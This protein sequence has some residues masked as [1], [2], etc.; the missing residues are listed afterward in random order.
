MSKNMI[1]SINNKKVAELVSCY[2]DKEELVDDE[3]QLR[4]LENKNN[5]RRKSFG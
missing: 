5:R 4:L 1:A 2:Y 3:F